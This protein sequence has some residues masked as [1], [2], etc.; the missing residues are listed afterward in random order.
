MLIALCYSISNECAQL[1]EFAEGL[2]MQQVNK[3]IY[4]GLTTDCCNKAV[5]RVDCSSK[6]IVEWSGLGLN[7]TLDLS[8]VPNTIMNLQLFNNQ[9]TGTLD[10]IPTTL[11]TLNVENNLLN[12]TIS[13]IP[14]SLQYLTFGIN[15]LTGT[16]PDLPEGLIGLNA[17]N[18]LLFGT[19]NS[20]PSTL[21]TLFISRNA[22]TGSLPSLP[23]G[24]IN[25]HC[26]GNYFTGF[27]PTLP[28]TVVSLKIGQGISDTNNIQ[29]SIVIN[30]PKLLNI[31]GNRITNLVVYNTG[32]LKYKDNCYISGNPLL[33]SPSITNLTTVCV[34]DD[35][36]EET[37]ELS[38]LVNL[39]TQTDTIDYFSSYSDSSSD[40]IHTLDYTV[41]TAPLKKT[42]IVKST[43]VSTDVQFPRTSTKLSLVA[44]STSTSG[45]K[46]YTVTTILDQQS[47]FESNWFF[48]SKNASAEQWAFSGIALVI[49]ALLLIIATGLVIN[50]FRKP[51]PDDESILTV[52]S[53][54][55][56]KK[57]Q[58][59]DREMARD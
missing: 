22:F 51:H 25:L 4:Q 54:K 31:Q 24:L 15:K 23:D 49:Y 37:N 35:L 46:V 1:M 17:F 11:R 26:N 6:W 13:Y 52:K 45:P 16:L 47:T 53:F 50:R 40:A 28:S 18:N 59:Q 57:T 36:Y 29:G 39:Q 2:N 9:L 5:T 48:P 34:A 21:R 43:F 20:L 27:M 33:N 14:S 42:R 44:N 38:S 58:Q 55:K 10:N 7:G 3:T 8:M 12:G 30:T 19:I 32:L 41:T 56:F